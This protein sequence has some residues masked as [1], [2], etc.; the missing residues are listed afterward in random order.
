[1]PSSPGPAPS[2]EPAA[3]GPQHR[4]SRAK[5][6]LTTLAVVA[7][8]GWAVYP[9]ILTYTFYLGEKATA[10]VTEC[11]VGSPGYGRATGD[12]DICRGTWRTEGGGTGDGEIYN[13][14][15]T[16]AE[17]RTF[18]VRVGPLGPYAHGWGRAWLGPLLGAVP[19]LIFVA[20]EIMFY[21]GILRPGR[22]LADSL[23]AAP[24][25]LL[26]SDDKTRHAD[27]T[28]HT[29]VRN[30]PEAPPGHRRLDLPG[31][32]RR[33]DKDAVPKGG[34][35]FYQSVV[36]ADE[37]P[38]MLLEHRSDERLEPETVLLDP[39]GNPRLLLRRIDG[40]RFRILDPAGAE[41]GSARPADSAR[42]LSLEVWD[43]DE[44]MVAEAAGRGLMTWV[45]RIEEDAAPPLRDAALALAF[46]KLRSLY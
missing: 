39:S 31:R 46:V 22:K 30:L 7:F 2:A 33:Q 18:E 15:P 6:I 43:A 28:P 24:G 16:K 45:L 44:K 14:D 38:L 3:A 32:E 13:L 8:C 41:L 26:V 25:A 17:G 35:T 29:F 5:T 21:R 20:V 11:E 10:S 12:P 23:L 19:L 9:V 27:G 1:M 40:T 36:D 42:I 37:R 34:R 4:K